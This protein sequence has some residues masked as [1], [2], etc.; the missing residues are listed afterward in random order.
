MRPYSESSKVSAYSTVFPA[1]PYLAANKERAASAWSRSRGIQPSIS[2]HV[3]VEVTD[4]AN[5]A[6]A[7]GQCGLDLTVVDVT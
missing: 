6:P 3:R 7:V 1:S 5:D 2:H 4:N